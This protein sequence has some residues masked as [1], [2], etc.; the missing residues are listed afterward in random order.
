MIVAFI[1]AQIVLKKTKGISLIGQIKDIF[2]SGD[3]EKTERPEKSEK[4]QKTK[5]AKKEK[6]GDDF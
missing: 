3:T 5:K 2:R 6:K 1:A 4:T